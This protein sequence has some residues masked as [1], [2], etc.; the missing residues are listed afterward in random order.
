MDIDQF[1]FCEVIGRVTKMA[2]DLR[3]FVFFDHRIDF[4]GVNGG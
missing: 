3:P 2:G 1:I 4:I